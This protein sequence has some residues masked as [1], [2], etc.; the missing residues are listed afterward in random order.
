MLRQGLLN[1]R[2]VPGL[3]RLYWPPTSPERQLAFRRVIL[4]L[5]EYWALFMD[6]SVHYDFSKRPPRKMEAA[7]ILEAKT[8]ENNKP[9]DIWSD[10]IFC[11]GLVVS[12]TRSLYLSLYTSAQPLLLVAPGWTYE[13]PTPW[14]RPVVLLLELEWAEWLVGKA[15]EMQDSLLRAPETSPTD[16]KELTDGVAPPS[17]YKLRVWKKNLVCH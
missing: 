15:E 3:F 14:R 11:G 16:C 13:P 2:S 17:C 9:L 7:E 1:L 10:P 8:K 5:R 6:L 4:M 12:L